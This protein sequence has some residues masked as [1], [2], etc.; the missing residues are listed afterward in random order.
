[1][2]ERDVGFSIRDWTVHRDGLVLAVIYSI[3]PVSYAEFKEPIPQISYYTF[4]IVENLHCGSYIQFA[5]HAL[6][7]TVKEKWFENFTP[8]V[9][10]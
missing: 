3:R 5:L 7:N 9:I 10:F 8:V 2:G 4:R 1:M 6:C